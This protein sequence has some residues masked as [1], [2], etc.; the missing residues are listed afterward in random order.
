MPKIPVGATIA[1]TYDFAFRQFIQILRVIW[2]PWLIL[3]AGGLLLRSPTTSFS[4]AL[5]AH[6]FSAAAHFLA[7]IFPFYILTVILL[8]VQIAG[9]TQLALRIPSKSPYYFFSFGKPVWRLLGAFLL[10]ATIAFGSYLLLIA[11]GILLG[12]LVAILGK[13]VGFSGLTSVILAIAS[14]IALIAVFCGYIYSIVRASFLLN[15]IVIAEQRISLKRGWELAGGNFWRIFV[16]MLAVLVPMMIVQLALMFGFLSHGFPPMPPLGATADQIAANRLQ[17]AAWNA[18]MI[19]RMYDYWYIVYP[20]YAV[21]A[22][23][24]YGLACGAQCFAY[25]AL[26]SELPNTNRL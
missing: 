21:I 3:T 5:A 19:K 16:I 23:L 6:D 12:L 15:P 18:D 25:R 2:L 1:R 9:I 7:P 4:A 11:A 22:G 13:L 17:I 20:L 8:F 14:V 24:F 10:L 26:T